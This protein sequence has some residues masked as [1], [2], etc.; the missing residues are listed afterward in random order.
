MTDKAKD[1]F[2]GTARNERRSQDRD[3]DADWESKTVG[4]VLGRLRNL[5]PQNGD[6]TPDG[7]ESTVLDTLRKRIE[8]DLK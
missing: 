2:K 8:D 5:P 4:R 6:Q 3:R 7:W 1:S